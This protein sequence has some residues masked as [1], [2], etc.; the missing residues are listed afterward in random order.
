VETAVKV[1]TAAAGAWVRVEVTEQ[2]VVGWGQAP[3]PPPRTCTPAGA[4]AAPLPSA[5]STHACC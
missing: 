2:E 1:A 4:T 3:S 5:L